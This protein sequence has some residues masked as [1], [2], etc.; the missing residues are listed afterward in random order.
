MASTIVT[1]D[2]NIRQLIEPKGSSSFA[3]FAMLK[4]FRKTNASVGLHTMPIIPYLTD[5]FTN[6]ESLCSEAQKAN[7]HYMLPGVLYLRGATRKVFFDFILQTYPE[8]YEQLK[9]LYK[10]GGADEIYKG[11]LYNEVVNP[12]REKYQISS[13]YTKPMKEKMHKQ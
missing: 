7:V 12:L 9:D 6:I 1:T 8:K 2:E 3:R 4:E 5:S 13:S 10:K 11:R